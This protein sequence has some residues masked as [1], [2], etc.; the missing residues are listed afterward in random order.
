MY[1]A[2]QLVISQLVIRHYVSLEQVVADNDNGEEAIEQCHRDDITGDYATENEGNT[3]IG[4]DVGD[5]GDM[6]V[7]VPLGG[8]TEPWQKSD[9]SDMREGRRE[10]ISL[11]FIQDENVGVL[12]LAP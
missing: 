2:H 8:Q 4:D 6:V 1:L 7:E 5:P 12:Y 10:H 11:K 9:G 3:E